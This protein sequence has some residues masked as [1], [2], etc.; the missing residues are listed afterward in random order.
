[1][2]KKPY[3]IFIYSAL[4]FALWGLQFYPILI[5]TRYKM[6]YFRTETKYENGF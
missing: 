6:L 4:K 5:K 1:M 3:R 2:K